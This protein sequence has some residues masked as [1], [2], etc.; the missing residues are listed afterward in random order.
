MNE[1]VLIEKLY[2]SVDNRSVE[3]L[4]VFLAE[5][6]RFR[7]ANH[8]PVVGKKA[9]LEANQA[10]FTSIAS[11]SHRIDN[12]WS[13]GEDVICNGRVDYIRLDGSEFSAPFATVLKLQDS[14]IVDYQVYADISEL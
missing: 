9:V 6:V 10:F 5:D 4:S 7:I 3:D 12:V 14:N 1:K 2:K 13:Q 8:D 11:M